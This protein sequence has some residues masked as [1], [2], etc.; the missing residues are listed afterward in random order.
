M[1]LVLVRRFG[2]RFNNF[3]EIYLNI[4]YYHIEKV[5]RKEGEFLEFI[6]YSVEN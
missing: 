2:F 6:G 1:F 4:F 5:K 3:G